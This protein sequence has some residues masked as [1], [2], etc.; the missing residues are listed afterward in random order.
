MQQILN[1]LPDEQLLEIFVLIEDQH[2]QLAIEYLIRHA[3]F[4]RQEAVE[5]IEYLMEQR[6][7][8]LKRY[9]QEDRIFSHKSEHHSLLTI[10]AEDDFLDEF[11]INL[12]FSPTKR[13]KPF[14]R[15]T[16]YYE[17]AMDTVFAPYFIYLVTALCA[18][19]LSYI[20][21]IQT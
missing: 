7:N 12:D 16:K 13:S 19:S 11:I 6:R 14:F 8:A 20:L 1:K 21:Y 3:K 18:L 4:N 2:Q 9:I 5:S 10:E 17:Y 15:F